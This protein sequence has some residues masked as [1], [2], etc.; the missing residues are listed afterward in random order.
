MPDLKLLL[1]YLAQSLL[2]NQYSHQTCPARLVTGSQPYAAI[3]MEKFVEQHMI[4]P[5][6]VI[7]Q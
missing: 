6:G 7:S 2:L 4:T 3:A 5:T 1:C